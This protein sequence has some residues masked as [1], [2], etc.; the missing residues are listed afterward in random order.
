[1]HLPERADTTRSPRFALTGPHA[2]AIQRRRDMLVG[3]S[4]RHAPHDRQSF[5]G[6]LASMLA[7]LGF[8]DAELRVLTTAPM[9]RENDVTR[10]LRRYRRLYR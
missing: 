3:P 10:P 6:R 7:G 2:H 5:V 1:M 9:D 8:A 4:S